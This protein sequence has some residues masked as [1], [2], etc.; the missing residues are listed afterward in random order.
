MDLEFLIEKIISMDLFWEANYY[1]RCMKKQPH[2]G[3]AR[4]IRPNVYLKH[5]PADTFVLF[6][7][8]PQTI[9][10]FIQMLVDE[11]YKEFLNCEIDIDELLSFC[12]DDDSFWYVGY[13]VLKPK[14]E[15]EES[16]KEVPLIWSVISSKS[17]FQDYFDFDLKAI[18]YVLICY[19]IKSKM[20]SIN[21]IEEI[22]QHEQLAVPHNKYGLMLTN[23]A[24][25]LRQG[26]IFNEKYYLYNLFFDTTIGNPNDHLPYT[27]KIIEEE[28]KDRNLFMRCDEK[29][30]VPKSEIIST[31]TMDFQKFRGISIDFIDIDKIVH[32]KEIVV[33]FDPETNNKVVL[34]IKPDT[35]KEGRSFYHFEV[36]ELWNPNIIKDHFVITNYIHAQY[37]PESKG[38]NHIDFSVNQYT[39]EIFEDKFRDSVT[40]T[41]IPIDRYGEEHYKIWCVESKKIDIE[42]WAKLVQATLDEPFRPL[43]AEM[44]LNLE[45]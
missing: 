12:F 40:D 14:K 18:V 33:H 29:L 17:R 1:F 4:I 7:Q 20:I 37:Y 25:Y 41:D 27:L 28:I 45:V 35:D 16:D 5:Y 19:L 26:F 42:T 3:V 38:F 34:I 24:M 2:G 21:G 13:R 9:P 8:Q 10:Y 11:A 6:N 39:K 30:G 31:A 32:K 36:E 22:K 15:F 43:F 23:G 44:F